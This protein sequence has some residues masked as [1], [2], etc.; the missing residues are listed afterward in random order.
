MR[1]HHSSGFSLRNIFENFSFYGRSKILFLPFFFPG[2]RRYRQCQ[3]RGVSFVAYDL[4]FYYYAVQC[5]AGTGIVAGTGVNPGEGQ[6]FMFDQRAHST[7]VYSQNF[8]FDEEVTYSQ[9]KDREIN[10]S[11]VSTKFTPHHC[12]QNYFQN[13]RLKRDWPQTAATTRR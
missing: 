9:Y 7:M 3:R 5:T 11:A 4:R 10:L 1:V 6:N 12:V 2:R 8:T 13:D